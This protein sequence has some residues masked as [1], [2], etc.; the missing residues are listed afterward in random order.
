MHPD[1]LEQW[2]HLEMKV[3]SVYLELVQPEVPQ[4]EGEPREPVVT[5]VNR[6][7][8]V[9]QDCLD[10]EDLT[11]LLVT[12]VPLAGHDKEKEVYRDPQEGKEGLEASVSLVMMV[13]LVCLVTEETRE[14]KDLRVQLQ[15]HLSH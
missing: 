15:N 6:E 12:K 5:S 14:K 10:P 3:I 9:L 13:L 7:T 11:E 2:D 4:G 8:T 1:H